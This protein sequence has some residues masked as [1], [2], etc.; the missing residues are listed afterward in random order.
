MYTISFFVG[1]EEGVRNGG[2][3]DLYLTS[4]GIWRAGQPVVGIQGDLM[5]QQETIV[6]R[7]AADT[8]LL[9][10]T[11]KHPDR[12]WMVSQ[13][14]SLMFIRKVTTLRHG[15]QGLVDQQPSMHSDLSMAS[16][17]TMR[18]LLIDWRWCCSS[19]CFWKHWSPEDRLHRLSRTAA[20]LQASRSTPSCPH[21]H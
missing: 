18:L 6:V 2:L 5:L 1:S 21:D 19:V 11:N 20:Q 15:S 14:M 9:V 8:I 12:T 7:L 17:Y 13:Q 3:D 16:Q 10:H 4:L